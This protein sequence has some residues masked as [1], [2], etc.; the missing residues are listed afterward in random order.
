MSICENHVSSPLA[1]APVPQTFPA[2]VPQEPGSRGAEPDETS[3]NKLPSAGR[4]KPTAPIVLV[5]HGEAITRRMLRQMLESGGYRVLE[6]EGG[7]EAVTRISEKVSVA[8]VDLFLPDM[9]GLKCLAH[10]RNHFCDTQVI[11]ISGD[12]KSRDGV[13]AMTHGAFAYLTKPWDPNE[14]VIRVRQAVRAFMLARENRALKQAVTCPLTSREL[15]GS[16]PQMH[17][18]RAQIEKL[19]QLDSTVLITGAGGT[20]KMIAAQSIHRKGPRATEPFVSVNCGAS[21]RELIEAELF[22][23]A[24][25][26][27]A[28]ATNDRPG[29]AEIADGGTLLLDEVGDLPIELQ[30][31]LLSFLRERTVQRVGSNDV[32]AVNV[33]VIGTTR[34]DL[35]EMCRQGRFR[36]DLYFRINVLPL[37]IPAL[38]EHFTDIPELANEILHQIAR[39]RGCPKPTLSDA[40]MRALQ[41]YSWPG[42][43]REMENALER[44]SASCRGAT[45]ER[46]DLILERIH[47]DAAP[48]DGSENLGLAGMTLAEIERRAVIETL[49]ACG[50]NRVRTAR[51]L[52]VSEKTIYNKIKQY[53]LT[54]RI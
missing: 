44:A 38:R 42:N 7:R 1:Q 51:Q 4:R 12:G 40:A 29:R 47:S 28:G 2:Q 19:A 53:K 26:S 13:A 20:G 43:T 37:H 18:V 5:A 49:R 9:S 27:F 3:P 22:G 10:I 8:I 50:G 30:P 31:R 11:V 21:P 34:R 25:S 41:Q 32:S 17:T 35:A 36:E 6:A 48:A 24:Q 14:L 46:K 45:I 15:L 54:G 39:R 23:H 33:R 16:S 52:G